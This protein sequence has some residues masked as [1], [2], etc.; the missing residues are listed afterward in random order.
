MKNTLTNAFAFCEILKNSLLCHCYF[1]FCILVHAPTMTGRHHRRRRG[2]SNNGI[3]N[4]G[5]GGGGTISSSSSSSSSMSS[6]SAATVTNVGSRRCAPRLEERPNAHR[7]RV[8]A[9]FLALSVS[10]RQM[11]LAIEDAELVAMLRHMHSLASE[12]GP[13][14][15]CSFRG[16]VDPSSFR[17]LVWRRTDVL[18][19][20]HHIFTCVQWAWV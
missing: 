3:S 11:A 17:D 2:A 15:F 10:E 9:W 20:T 1:S 16:D 7:A 12:V 18:I 6:S 19:R 13:L 4:G 14:L 8:R 5:G